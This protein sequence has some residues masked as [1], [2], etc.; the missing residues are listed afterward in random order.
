[1]RILC[2]FKR[3]YM[4]K[5]VLSDRYARLY[6]LPL[7]LARRGHEVRGICLNYRGAGRD[8]VAVD[9]RCDGRLRWQ[10]FD[11]GPLLLPG[12][13]AWRRGVR[14]TIE[15]F[16]PDLLLGGSDSPH[17]AATHRFAREAGLPFAVDLFDNFASFGL[18]RLPGLEGAYRAALG[19]ADAITCVSEPL[20]RMVSREYA[21]RGAVMTLESTINRT[22]FR[23]R[24]RAACRAALGLPPDARLIGTAGALDAGRGIDTLYAAFARLRA[25][26]SNLHLVLAGATHDGTP[27]P[28]TP[29]VLHLGTIDHARVA[30][31]FSALDV[32]L[33]C[34]RDTAF[35]RYAFPQKAYEIIACGTPV[36]AARVGAL[37]TLLADTPH[38]LYDPDD[39]D[40][41]CRCLTAQ[42]E[43]P[44]PCAVQPPDWASQA[45]RLDALL[46]GVLTRR[47]A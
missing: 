31:L 37:E 15:R 10:S 11:L 17:V 1:M 42:L 40:E 24:E 7:E 46:V 43:Q 9:E 32:A 47:A 12:L 29:G 27:L 6:E 13:A 41:L 35:G 23:P 21:P 2:L 34:L 16:A 44:M 4:S 30:E 18:S 45:A 26:D 25:R 3:R 33:V 19:A 28:T 22:L 20:S 38:A 5:D 39:V 36:V 8:F 14:A